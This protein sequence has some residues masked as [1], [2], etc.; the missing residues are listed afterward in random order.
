MYNKN[1]KLFQ[2]CEAAAKKARPPV[3]LRHE[4]ET[5]NCN[6]DDQKSVYDDRSED[7]RYIQ[8]SSHVCT[9]KQTKI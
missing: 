2:S 5:V 7:Q 9:C 8:E 4:L 6:F 1:T 3:K